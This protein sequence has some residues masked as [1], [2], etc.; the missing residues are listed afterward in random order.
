[1]TGASD[2]RASRPLPT[3]AIH[4]TSIVR[5]SYY[6]RPGSIEAFVLPFLVHAHV[7]PARPA[8]VVVAIIPAR[9]NSTRLPGKPLVSL[10]GRPLIEHVYRRACMAE[11]ISRVLVATDDVRIEVAVR[12]F[13]G[14]CVMTDPAHRSGTDR[15]A[16][17]TASVSCDV[18]VNVQGDEPLIAPEMITAAIG[19]FA[20]P[21]VQMTTIRRTLASREELDDPNVVKVVVD[22]RGDALYFS[23]API[24]WAR[25]ASDHFAPGVTFRHVGLYAY[26]R[27][28]LL[29]F[30]ALP[31]GVLE[32]AES[33]EQLRALEH[34]MRIRT[35]ETTYDSI[36]VDTPADLVR[37]RALLESA[38]MT[39]P[40][41][42]RTA[43]VPR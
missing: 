15:L 33:L 20:D 42:D 8:P 25:D 6:R 37:V 13:G 26:R 5:L 35:V 19:P 10:D 39:P 23:R 31:P 28:C 16:E 43:G 14:E 41:G 36:G 11:G 12:A 40:G 38:P 34:G 21:A 7:R 3:Y 32:L 9:F 27:E 30:A 18:V 1:M 29:A 2:T 17:A 22:A 24:P 4:R